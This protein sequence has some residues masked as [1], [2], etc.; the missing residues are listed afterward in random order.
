MVGSAIPRFKALGIEYSSPLQGH[1]L[2]YSSEVVLLVFL[3][4][5]G[6]IKLRIEFIDIYVK[7]FAA[8]RWLAN[9]RRSHNLQMN[10]R[11]LS[12]C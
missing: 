2:H 9:L 7:G 10:I 5:F 6:A 11:I 1:M 3:V 4:C 12:K 8:K